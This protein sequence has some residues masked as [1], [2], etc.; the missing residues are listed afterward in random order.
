MGT[1]P[2]PPVLREGRIVVP[3]S[4]R[5]LAAYGL[6]PPPSGQHRAAESGSRVFTAKV[7]E[8]ELLWISFDELCAPGTS[9]EDYYLL[10]AGAEAWVIDGVPAPEPGHAGPRAEAWALFASALAVLAVRG[11]TL[12]VVGTA[13]MDWAAA[14]SAACGDARLRSAF[15]DIDRLLAKLK[16]VESDEAVAVEGTSG[17]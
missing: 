9:W 10:A 14:A 3:G 1:D 2:E 8:P 13:P 5:Q 6:F 16:R 15:E 4:S 7:V 17:S 11:T 12:F